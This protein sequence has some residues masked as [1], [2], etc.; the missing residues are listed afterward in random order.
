M[1]RDAKYDVTSGG[2][3]TA[4]WGHGLP[5]D[6]FPRLQQNQRGLSLSQHL[7]SKGICCIIHIGVGRGGWGGGGRGGGGGGGGGQA[8]PI[9]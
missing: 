8:P 4:S 2:L 5:P 9:I 7:C 6:S 3:S 1:E